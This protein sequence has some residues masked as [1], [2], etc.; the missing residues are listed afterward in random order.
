[1][2]AFCS[3]YHITDVPSFV[4]REYLYIF[5]P[6]LQY[7]KKHITDKSRPGKRL[8]F[9]KKIA[10]LSKQLV[11][12]IGLNEFRGNQGFKGTMFR[13]PFRTTGS[14]IS[15]IQ[16]TEHHIGQLRRDISEC[17]DKL[18]LFLQSVKRL[19]FSRI[20]EGDDNPH[21]VLEINK[22][23]INSSSTETQM[24][25]IDTACSNSEARCSHWV[26]GIPL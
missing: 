20:D 11:P 12:F 23:L 2:W 17:G 4:S 26:V 8:N 3:V 24:L 6:T 7:L 14:E 9:T 15:Q 18:L 10:T 22:E 1:M 25:R 21:L 5:D 13:F 19:T 16:Y